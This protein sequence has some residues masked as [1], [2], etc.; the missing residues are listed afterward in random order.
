MT[1]FV[2]GFALAIAVGQLA[3]LFGVD[4]GGTGF[5][6]KLYELIGQLPG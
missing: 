1:G 4:G 6:G 5:F 3:K 2:A